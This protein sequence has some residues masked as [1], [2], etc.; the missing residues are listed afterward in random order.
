M[1]NDAL[2]ICL[3]G[4]NA[5][6][7]WFGQIMDALPGAFNFILAMIGVFTV[8]RLLLVPIMGV[9]IGG[10]GSDMAHIIRSESNRNKADQERFYQRVRSEVAAEKR[11]QRRIA[12][13][14]HAKFVRDDSRRR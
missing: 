14:E 12:D 1:I 9:H 3:T 11:Y 13:R 7:T 5:V 4:I 2:N 6:F 8:F 10:A